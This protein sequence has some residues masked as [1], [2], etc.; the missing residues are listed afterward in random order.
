VTEDLAKDLADPVF[1]VCAL[2]G[3]AGALT[4][5]LRRNPV[6]SALGLLAAFLSFAVIF[7]KLHAPFLAAMHVLVYTGAIL[8]LFLFVIMLL[9]LSETE[10]GK[11]HGRAV[12]G[13]LA[14][15]AAGLCA[16]LVFA[17]TK[18]DSLMRPEK[19]LAKAL[20]KPLRVADTQLPPITADAWG[21]VEH[22]GGQLFTRW[23]FAFEL[24]SLLIIVAILGAV[25][26]AKKKLPPEL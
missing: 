25:V 16:V 19:D 9:N 22:V 26:L 10:L 8:V 15:L 17:M 1:L 7:I 4:V 20:E 3:V 11:E 21:G 6:Y 18:D 5:V 23:A 13:A 12:K 14:V 24:V 2:V